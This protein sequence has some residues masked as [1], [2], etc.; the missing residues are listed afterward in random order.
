M[1]VRHCGDES[2]HKPHEWELAGDVFSCVG[3]TEEGE[4]LARRLRYAG[5]PRW[6]PP[7]PI[8][9]G[10]TMCGRK[11]CVELAAVALDG[12]PRC[13]PHADEEIERACVDPDFAR[14][15]PELDE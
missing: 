1:S 4:A 14:L 11:R 8:E 3:T 7:A 9:W 12:E 6:S 15:L 10:S 5:G 2:Q 13:I